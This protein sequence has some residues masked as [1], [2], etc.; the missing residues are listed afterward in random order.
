LNLVKE[1]IDLH[2]NFEAEGMHFQEY[3]IINMHIFDLNTHS[4]SEIVSELSWYQIQYNWDDSATSDSDGCLN[5]EAWTAQ[6]AYSIISDLFQKT[7]E[8]YSQFGFQSEV[9]AFQN[10]QKFLKNIY[11]DLDDTDTTEFEK[12][13]SQQVTSLLN[14]ADYGEHRTYYSLLIKDTISKLMLFESDRNNE[15]E[16]DMD[17]RL[18]E[19]FKKHIWK[20][21]SAFGNQI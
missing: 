6:Q 5:D 1:E 8:I 13:I 4:L 11:F 15:S 3:V 10:V 9:E 20:G 19:V 12:W 21:K 17:S 14:S 16:V 18:G 2:L 7:K